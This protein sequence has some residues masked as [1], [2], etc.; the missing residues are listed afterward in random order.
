MQIFDPDFRDG[1]ARQLTPFQKAFKKNFKALSVRSLGTR[2]Y[3]TDVQTW[4]CDC[5]QQ[6]YNP[7]IL[8]KHL[9]QALQPP[10]ADF[11]RTVVRRRVIPFYRHPL[12]K[13][14]DGSP[15]TE[16]EIDDPGSITDGDLPT[17]P[18]LPRARGTKRK[19]ASPPLAAPV[20]AS[21]DIGEEDAVSELLNA[22]SD[23][24]SSSPVAVDEYEDD[25]ADACDWLQ[26]RVTELES[27]I[28]MMKQQLAHPAQAQIWLRSMKRQNMGA[29]VAQLVRDVR[30]STETG[31]KRPSTWGKDRYTQNTMG[32]HVI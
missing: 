30:H 17:Q 8:C 18:P 3:N 24:R 22:R 7:Y 6:K 12:L 10:P 32:Y 9:V 14:A 5:G 20:P 11:F 1:R 15:V 25:T 16:I 27:G 23:S 26:D 2:T 29:D 4:T 19:R 21:D 31:R 28:A 13:L